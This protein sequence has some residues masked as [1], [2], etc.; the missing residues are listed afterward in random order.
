MP[1]AN[2]LQMQRDLSFLPA[3]YGLP[4][5][6]VFINEEQANDGYCNYLKK[7]FSALPQPV[8]PNTI[9]TIPDAEICLWG[10]TPQAIHFFDEV[11]RIDG[12][13]LK[14]PAWH[15]EYVY[16]NGRQAAKD[17]LQHLIKVIL[18]ID[19]NLLPRFCKTMDEVEAINKTSKQPMLAKAPYSSSGRG[20]VWLNNSFLST[21]EKEIVHGILKKQHSISLE[22]VLNK[23]L[24]FAMQFMCDGRGDARFEGYSLFET[25]E[26]GTYAGNFLC[27][28]EKM[29]DLLTKH[30]PS[31]LL[32]NVKT[33]LITLLKSMCAPFYKGCIGVDM[34][35]YEKDG[36]IC[37]HPCVE[38]NMRYNM[39]YLALKIYQNYIHP[40]SEG[41][42]QL[43]YNN[44]ETHKQHLKCLKNL[45]LQ[46]KNEKIQK[47][48]LSLCPSF[49]RK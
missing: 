45:P 10:I 41:K 32:E 17:C 18:E 12:L 4:G 19:E 47:G 35:L 16:L 15:D 14:I 30:I 39:G 1:P 2:V 7:Q 31:S 36:K 8:T 6:F 9:S 26:K 24:D 25:T 13:Q 42:L 37:L 48:Y 49:G 44:F 11:N 33:Q 34:M 46:F 27:R 21:K 5:D 3:W 23:K 29:A 28:Q 43:E 22:C 40:D 20:V 38:I